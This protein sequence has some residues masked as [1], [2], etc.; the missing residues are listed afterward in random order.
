M[1]KHRLHE[2][3][4][5]FGEPS[6]VHV[7]AILSNIS[8]KYKNDMFIGSRI[9]PTVP[10]GKRS[11]KYYVYDRDEA[12]R[13][14]DD[15][16]GPKARP[17]EIDMKQ[18]TDNYSVVSRGLADWVP[19]E[20]MDNA[21]APLDPLADATEN[22][23]DKLMLA[24]EKRIADQVQAASLYPAGNK[25]QLSGT[26]QWDDYVN[27][28]PLGDLQAAIEATFQRANIVAMG[29][30]TWLKLRAHPKVLD[31]VKAS[32]R[33]QDTPGGFATPEELITLLEIQQLLIGRSRINTTKRGQ[34][35]SYSRIWGKHCMAF[36]TNPSP[37]IK[38]VSFGYT[39]S[40]NQGQTFRSFDGKRGE[41]GATYI[42]DAWN[43]DRKVVAADLGYLIEDAVS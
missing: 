5:K 41:K 38:Q 43:E 19:Q 11:D 29:V 9:F 36:H 12:F 33:L 25:V 31:A 42:K 27:S 35:A 16:L 32:T 4:K 28:D 26:D 39:F 20:E 15:T 18:S 22:L 10:V 23:R 13:V 1:S 21:D 17:N 2:E 3:T 24:H 7:D 8:I 14:D 40:E 34:A 30:D 37:G 6:D